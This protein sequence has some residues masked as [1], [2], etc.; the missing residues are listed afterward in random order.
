MVCVVNTTGC[1]EEESS[2][3]E[4]MVKWIGLEKKSDR[5]LEIK[6]KRIGRST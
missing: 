5:G 6:F 1:V 3:E 2:F 4:A